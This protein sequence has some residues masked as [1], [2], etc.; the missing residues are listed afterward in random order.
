MKVAIKPGR[1]P[2]QKFVQFLQ[3]NSP[4]RIEVKVRPQIVRFH[5]KH[6]FLQDRGCQTHRNRS[7]ACASRGQERGRGYP[8]PA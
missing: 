1:R 3:I 4:L 7:D 6:I 5:T 2:L 8:L